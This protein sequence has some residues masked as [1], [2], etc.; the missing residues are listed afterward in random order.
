VSRLIGLVVSIA[1]ADSLNP[2]TIAPGLYLA[3]GRRPRGA[4][5]QFTLGVLAVN[6]VGG[7]AIA[8]GP[9]QAILALVPM[10]GHTARYIAE[11]VAGVVMLIGAIVL[12]R[13][14]QPLAR[15][16][17]FRPPSSEGKSAAVLGITIA[18]I[19]LPTA[20][21]YF[22]A[23]AAI[24][25]SGLDAGRQ[26]ILIGIYNLIFVLPLISMIAIIVVAPEQATSILRRIRELLERRWPALLAGVALLVGIF[27]TVLGV[28]GLA[29]GTHGTVG[30]LSRR[31][32]R[33]IT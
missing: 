29:S 20:F 18:G 21:P 19:E 1:F 10:P 30:L 22:A 8:L 23:I 17:R 13:R 16:H 9:G 11:T 24:V 5:I 25:S 32:R 2:S 6:L 26:L 33:K 3:S 28:T 31:L 14:R 4:L 27:V 7:A 12:W 15:R